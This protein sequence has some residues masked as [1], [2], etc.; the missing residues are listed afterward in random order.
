MKAL[1]LESALELSRRSDVVLIEGAG[2]LSEVNLLPFDLT[3]F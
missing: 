1:I 2:A 3:N